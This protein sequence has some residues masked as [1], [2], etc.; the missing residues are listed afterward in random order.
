MQQNNSS[1][2]YIFVFVRQDISLAQQAVQSLHAMHKMVRV[3]RPDYDDTPNIVYIGLPN[4][5]SLEKALEKLKA[6]QIVHARWDEP[7]FDLGFTSIATAPLSNQEKSVLS[8]Y[9]V[10]KFT[11]GEPSNR[12]G[13]SSPTRTPDSPVGVT[14]PVC[15]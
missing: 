15:L 1:D 8:N 2:K 13:G 7:D 14:Q 12:F 5:A 9:R 4:R 6:H 10:W 11:P 3:L